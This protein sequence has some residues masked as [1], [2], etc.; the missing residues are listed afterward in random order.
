MP[1]KVC[2]SA[3]SKIIDRVSFLFDFTPISTV[4]LLLLC[5]NNSHVTAQTTPI[6]TKQI[7]SVVAMPIDSTLAWMRKV[8]YKNIDT[9][10]QV[11][12]KNLEKAYRSKDVLKIAESHEE[13]AN[14]YGYHGVFPQDST[15]YHCEKTLEYYILTGDK[16]KI[17]KTYRTLAID[18]LRENSQDKSQT[19]LF[20]A[21][22]LYEELDDEQG[23]AAVYRVL[24]V[25]LGE[26][27]KPEE[28]IKYSE[29]AIALFKKA[30]NYASIAIAH[31]DLI[32]GYTKL[33]E[34]D[35]AYTAANNCID[36]VQTKAQ[37]EVFVLVRAYSY[38][39][40]VSIETKDYEQALKD[41]T[42]AWELCVVQ[43]GEERASTYRT[44]I[45]NALRLQGNY[46]EGAEHLLSGIKAYEAD[47]N[48][49]IW[50]LYDQLAD[51][52]RNLGNPDKALLYFEKSRTIRDKIYQD[53]IKNLE[54]EALIKYETGKKDEALAAQAA[55]LEQ[56]N[57]VQ[58]LI[59]G[60]GALLLALLGL[61]FYFLRKSKKAT[62]QITVKNAEN[63]LLL[64]EIHHRVK[65]NLEMVKSLIALQS[66]QLEDSA[67]KDAMIASQNRVQSMGIIH[68]KLYQ[69]TNLGSI[70]MKDYFINLG[71]GILDTFNAD[72]K[73]KIALAMETLELDV[74]TAV[75]IGL[76]V[77][78]LLTNSLK[79]AFPKDTKGQIEIS[80][81]K[82]GS[83][84]LNLKVSDN[85]V[86]KITGMPA[87]GT[88]FGS[89][90][91]Q[92]LTQQ[93]NGKMQEET[94]NGTIISF[95]FKLDKAA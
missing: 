51:C 12:L 16:T 86:G 76:I 68:Q 74:D 72:E 29:Q 64:K 91:V 73:V 6:S 9:Y 44:E 60:I 14:W 80:L 42:K 28:S 18:Y 24:G 25:L 38:R 5:L 67:T 65:N 47:E 62:Q 20:K 43:I 79:Y 40:D 1:T 50:P 54:T 39:G 37:E 41:Y 21:L 35:K 17:A 85:G 34:F 81:S 95:E 71:E 63:E 94:Q 52:Y 70:E 56:K 57:K 61:L 33:G 83:D 92:L 23:M 27:E 48:E 78:E 69:G 89:Q 45:G 53:Q 19:S 93:L 31:F 13:M 82:T 32:K 7:D 8:Q 36:I 15:L 3:K 87:K 66:A 30:D 55:V 77:N 26:M 90:L 49:R 58:N 88:G 46:K 59:I 10:Q 2:A 84:I 11:G 4:L 22:A 75:P